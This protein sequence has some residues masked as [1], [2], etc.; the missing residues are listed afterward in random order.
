MR[1]RRK[2][3]ALAMI[4][5]TIAAAV[6]LGAFAWQYAQQTRVRREA[7]RRMEIALAALRRATIERRGGINPRFDPEGCGIIGTV[8]SPLTSKVGLLPAKRSTCNPAFAAVVVELLQQAK[9]E[10]GDIIAVAFSGSFPALNAATLIAAETLGLKPIVISSVSASMFGANA[11]QLTWVDMESVLL[12]AGVIH[13]RSS[14]A[15]LGAKNDNGKGL[16]PEGIA[17]AKQAAA[18]NGVPLLRTRSLRRAIRSRLR[19]YREVAQGNGIK[20]YVNV[21]GGRA[22]VGSA[23]TKAQFHPG[24]NESPPSRID[25]P[26]VMSMFSQQGLPVIHLGGIRKLCK[27][28]GLPFRG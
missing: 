18:R 13:T 3:L 23:R 19:L 20:A 12:K 16:S 28:H 14:A 27:E 8:V 26:G 7:T 4:A 15:T 9:L 22:S 17:L 6:S 1:R 2:T 10:S 25:Q 21:G 5:A 11:P 24:L